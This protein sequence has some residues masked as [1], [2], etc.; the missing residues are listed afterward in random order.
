MNHSNHS[1]LFDVVVS[2][3]PAVSTSLFRTWCDGW[4]VQ[5]AVKLRVSS[6]R[7]E[8]AQSS[9]R[10]GKV[11][12]Y[13]FSVRRRSSSVEATSEHDTA[14]EQAQLEML[15]SQDTRDLYHVYDTLEHF[16]CEPTLLQGQ[17]MIPMS[18]SMQQA[19]LHDYYSFDAAVLRELLG[20][21]LGSKSRKDLDDVAESTRSALKSCRRQ[22]DNLRRMMTFLDDSYQFHCMAVREIQENFLL[23]PSLAAQ[24]TA[25]TYLLHH[26]VQLHTSRGTTANL[27]AQSLCWCAT[28]MLNCWVGSGVQV[29]VADDD[30]KRRNNA[31]GLMTAQEYKEHLQPYLV[32]GLREVWGFSIDK[33]LA[34]SLQRIRSLLCGEHR[35][36]SLDRMVAQVMVALKPFI[37]SHKQAGLGTSLKTVLN[38][39][40]HIGAH[41]SQSKEQR[42]ILEDIA[43]KVTDPLNSAGLDSMDM[44]RLCNEL[45]TAFETIAVTDLPDFPMEQWKRYMGGVKVCLLYTS[46]T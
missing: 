45:V 3:P 10:L 29:T 16:L 9:N 26:K 7:Q 31:L 24:Y 38:R 17:I 14:R 22:F 34:S 46:S 1:T 4:S 32:E 2:D 11:H 12:G 25:C 35:G 43:S 40:L 33:V 23:Q 44:V 15:F 8:M 42:D 13:E 28:G 21:K 37:S 20:K 30:E 19:L 27:S 41:V 18:V 6:F 5:Q 39:V 36:Q